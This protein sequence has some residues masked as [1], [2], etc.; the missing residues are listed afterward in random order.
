MMRLRNST[1]FFA[2]LIL[3]NTANPLCRTLFLQN[4]LSLSL[5]VA[6]TREQK[7]LNVCVPA[8]DKGHNCSCCNKCMWTLI[9]LDAMGKL[10]KFKG[11]FDIDVYKKNAFKQKCRFLAH[12]GKDSM[13]T[14]I[15]RYAKE[16]VM[17]L[18]PRRVAKIYW[19]AFRAFRKIGLFKG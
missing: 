1:G 3:R 4:A 14:S 2:I 8:T 5:M 19:F 17:K 12:Y 7:Y 18:P 16:H 11:V 6:S 13:E 9:P 15:T 10:D